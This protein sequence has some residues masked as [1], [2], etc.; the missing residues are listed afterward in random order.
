MY[1][2]P[3]DALLK[4]L[5]TTPA[6]V[7]GVKSVAVPGSLLKMLL[8]LAIASCDFDEQAYLEAN[9][10]VRKA[11]E[12]GAIESGHVHYIGFGYFEGRRGGTLVDE[13]WYLRKYPDVAAAI[14]DSRIKSATQHFHSIG[15]GE[16][17]SPN[18]DLMADAAQWKGCLQGQEASPARMAG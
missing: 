8:Q 3:Y 6:E 17:R 13:S 12:R 15:A 10:D 4:S 7:E 9:P 11:V 16:G 5:H 1:V 18:A 14:R 2:P